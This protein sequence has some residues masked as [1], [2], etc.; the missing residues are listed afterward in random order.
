MVER[1]DR[2]LKVEWPDFELLSI[3]ILARSAVVVLGTLSLTNTVKGDFCLAPEPGF[4]IDL[5]GFLVT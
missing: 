2:A 4:I 3:T 5:I 1:A